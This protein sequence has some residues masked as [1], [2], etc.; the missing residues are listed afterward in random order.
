MIVF[1]NGC[2]DILHYGHFKLLEYCAQTG[3]EVIVGL[4]SDKSV[5]K[6]KGDNRP[7]NNEHIRKYNLECI[8]FVDKVIIFNEETPYNLMKKISPNII[9]KGG[10][11]TVQSVIGNDLCEVRIY[12]YVEGYSTTKTIQDLI[13]R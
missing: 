9:V 4:N 2:F 6:I 3:G 7:F 11:Y 5:K 1:T 13:D 10:D 12:K 8:K